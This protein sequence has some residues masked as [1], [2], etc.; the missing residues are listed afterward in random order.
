VTSVANANAQAFATAT[1]A[2]ATAVSQ[3]VAQVSLMRATSFSHLA[4]A[5]DCFVVRH[6]VHDICQHWLLACSQ[7]VQNG[8]TVK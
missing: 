1:N 2:I 4:A 3:A 8:L 5:S 6:I 7:A